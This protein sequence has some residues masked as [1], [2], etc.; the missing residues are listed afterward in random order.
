MQKMQESQVGSLGQEYPLEEEMATYSSLE[1]PM[2]REESHGYSPWSHKGS[3]ITE[4][5]STKRYKMDESQKHY[6]RVQ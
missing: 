5:L 1:N 4:Q 2:D 6:Y 3:D